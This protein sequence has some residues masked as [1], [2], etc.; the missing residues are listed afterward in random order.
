MEDLS[1][2]IAALTPLHWLF[3]RR[4]LAGSSNRE[5]A[6]AAGMTPAEVRSV[7]ADLCQRFDV[8]SREEL[9]AACGAISAESN[10]RMARAVRR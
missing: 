10:H 3:L 5:L 4:I 6:R 2:V 9:K 7:L 1:A 8:K